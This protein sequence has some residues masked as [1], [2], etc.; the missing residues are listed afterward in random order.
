MP[1]KTISVDQETYNLLASAKRGRER[2]SS[3]IKRS[4]NAPRTGQ[5]LLDRLDQLCFEESTLDALERIVAQ[6]RDYPARVKALD[7]DA[8]SVS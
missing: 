3:V 4:L 2:F 8:K 7:T 6:R 5:Y 1:A